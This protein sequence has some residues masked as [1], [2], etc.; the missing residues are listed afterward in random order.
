MGVLTL[1]FP[2]VSAGVSHLTV[3][4]RN[5]TLVSFDSDSVPDDSIESF[6][7]SNDWPWRLRQARIASSVTKVLT[8]ATTTAMATTPATVPPAT[9]LAVEEDESLSLFSSAVKGYK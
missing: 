6:S 8:T 2:I 5:M 7:Q 9:P 3:P 1:G 4:A